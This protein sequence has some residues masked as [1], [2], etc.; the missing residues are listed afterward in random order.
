MK[1]AALTLSALMAVSPVPAS[2][3][4]SPI[5]VELY[6]SQGCSSCP[7]ADALLQ[8]LAREADVLPLAL[9]VDYWDY[10]GWADTFAS[11]HFT[12]RQKAYAVAA[13]HRR[14]YTPQMIIGGSDQVVGNVPMDVA[15]AIA[16]HQAAVPQVVILLKRE[17]DELAITL[18]PQGD[19]AGP[20][21]V[22]LVRFI[23]SQHVTIERGENAGRT[24]E[25]VNTVSSW[26]RVGE[27]DGKSAMSV[28]AATP[29]ADSI[30]VIVQEPGPGLILA[31]AALP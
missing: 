8:E 6:T 29:G 27:W 11:S 25:Y 21:L 10:I 12:E 15:S 4:S 9:H 3:Q 31:A 2:A 18:E 13:G 23:P 14:V 16:R 22:Q 5:V 24:I 19:L 26:Q 1:H 20:Y 17:G 30:A 28:S 7:P